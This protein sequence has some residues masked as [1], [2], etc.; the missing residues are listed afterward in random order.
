MMVRYRKQNTYISQYMS[1]WQTPEFG[2]PG[3]DTNMYLYPGKTTRYFYAAYDSDFVPQSSL[4]Y[5]GYQLFFYESQFLGRYPNND[6]VNR[7]TYLNNVSVTEV[8]EASISRELYKGRSTV[9][10]HSGAGLTES[11]KFGVM[12]RNHWDYQNVGEDTSSLSMPA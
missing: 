10:L 8:G 7:I 5:T 9:K 1:C 12:G 11:T 3:V 4:N 2:E 6:Y